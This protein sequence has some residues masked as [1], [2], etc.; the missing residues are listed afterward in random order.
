MIVFI[1]IARI[2]FAGCFTAANVI[3]ATTVGKKLLGTVYGLSI[4]LSNITR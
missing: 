3:M 2:A 1:L 4:A